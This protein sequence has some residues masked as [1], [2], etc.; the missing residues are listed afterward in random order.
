MIYLHTK[1]FDFESVYYVAGILHYNF[2]LYSTVQNHKNRPVLYIKAK[3]K[4]N[5][6]NIIKPYIHES[7]LYKLR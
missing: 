7:F 2:G 5:F 3:S 1:G 4:N 6:I